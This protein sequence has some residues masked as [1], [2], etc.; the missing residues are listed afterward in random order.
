MLPIVLILFVTALNL[1]AATVTKKRDSRPAKL[2]EHPLGNKFGEDDVHESC[3]GLTYCT[4]KPPN[5]PEEK[6]NELMKNYKIPPLPTFDALGNRQGDISLTDDCDFDTTYDPLYKVRTNLDEPW[7]LVVQAPG[8]GYVQ[9]VRSD[10]CK[11]TGSSCFK[12]FLPIPQ[13]ETSCEQIY[14]TWE[15]LVETADGKGMEPIKAT[16]PSCCSCKY[17][18]IPAVLTRFSGVESKLNKTKV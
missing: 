3:K 8:Q 15:V 1:D 14:N 17:K 7:R 18:Y 9:R 6:F 16:I 5:Y 13:H 12:P 10:I 2:Q 11:A 4:V